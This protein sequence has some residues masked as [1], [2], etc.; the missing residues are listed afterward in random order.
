MTFNRLPLAIM[1]LPLTLMGCQE[2]SP[3]PPAPRPVR[4]VVVEPRDIAETISQTGEIQP[5]YE[6]DLGFQINGRVT[7]RFVDVGAIVK[8]GDLLATLDESDVANE[9][10]AAEAEVINAQAAA[11]AALAAFRRQ[12][13]LFDK[14]ISA[15]AALE[16]AEAQWKSAA[17]KQEAATAAR[18]NAVNRRK[19]AELVATEG[20]VVTVVGANRGQ[21][22][23]AGQMVAR[24][25]SAD[26]RDGVF[27]VPE[28]LIADAAMGIPVVVSLTADP[29]VKT[30]GTLR[31]IS[32]TA[33]PSTR[34]YRVRVSLPNAPAAMALGTTVNGS[35]ALSNGRMI[36]VPGSAITSS[37][38]APAVFV[39]DPDSA[40]L[41]LK[42]VVVARYEDGAARIRSGLQAGDRVVT[43]G[44][45]KLRPDE[46]VK[47]AEPTP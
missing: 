3:P 38:G 27:N 35:V 24:V 44:V 47:L 10:K 20:G 29:T 7:R 45:S 11:Q 12:K 42:P 17:A 37:S 6:A 43:A 39:V 40:K 28:R 23:G 41:I 31:E 32:P 25:A 22:V 19:Y 26:A 8:P 34:T 1:A 18:E 15:K 5:R 33:D 36:S 2:A 16:N 30:V 9:L 13:Q 4:T 21:V 14:Q 46:P